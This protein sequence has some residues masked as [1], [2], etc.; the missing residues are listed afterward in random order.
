MTA[1]QSLL[2]PSPSCDTVAATRG[3]PCFRLWPELATF[4]NLLALT[5]TLV[6]SSRPP[7]HTHARTHAHIHVYIHRYA[8][9][10]SRENGDDDDEGDAH[11]AQSPALWASPAPGDPR[12]ASAEDEHH[13]VVAPLADYPSGDDEPQDTYH[14]GFDD[15]EVRG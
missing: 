12:A 8:V 9:P 4:G 2:W 11:G 10:G 6:P 7:A 1:K 5:T 13:A 14:Q 3:N 15:E